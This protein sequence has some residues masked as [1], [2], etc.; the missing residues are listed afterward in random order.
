MLRAPRVSLLTLCPLAQPEKAIGHESQIE[1][2]LALTTTL[3]DA[4][5]TDERRYASKMNLE[6]RKNRGSSHQYMGWMSERISLRL[7][8][9]GE[10][11]FL[12]TRYCAY[13]KSHSA[14]FTNVTLLHCAQ[15]LP[16]YQFA[17]DNGLAAGRWVSHQFKLAQTRM[18][19]GRERFFRAKAPR[20]VFVRGLKPRP[21]K[22]VSEMAST[23][24][25][26]RRSRLCR[27]NGRRCRRLDRLRRYC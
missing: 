13:R 15:N 4:S 8:V 9:A 6:N 10:V 21:L 26:G 14:V 20:G 19:L 3:L 25:R 27:C 1:L 18:E 23:G 5:E 11:F 7:P 16:Q 2:W 22:M 24:C 17:R 12:D